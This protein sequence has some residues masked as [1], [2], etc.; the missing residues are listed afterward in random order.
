MFV[1]V[2]MNFGVVMNLI[3]LNSRLTYMAEKVGHFPMSVMSVCWMVCWLVRLL[4][5]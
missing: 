3:S 5:S 1:N 2:I 4:A